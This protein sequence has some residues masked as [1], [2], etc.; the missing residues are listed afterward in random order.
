[1]SRLWLETM[2]GRFVRAG[3]IAELATTKLPKSDPRSPDRFTVTAYM[4]Y[5]SGSDGRVSPDRN[6]F[7]EFDTQ[8]L[9]KQKL[10]QLLRLLV[11]HADARAVIALRGTEI[12][13]EPIEPDG[14]TS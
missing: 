3:L 8:D 12:T 7:G 4:T 10:G 9:A 13:V 1:M 14:P 6:H 5:P 2:G 11:T